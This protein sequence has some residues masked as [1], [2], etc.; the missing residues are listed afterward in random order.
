MIDESQNKN[1]RTS[2]IYL[3]EATPTIVADAWASA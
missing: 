2:L 3:A 1:L